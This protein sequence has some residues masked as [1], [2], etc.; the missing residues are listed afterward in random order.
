MTVEFLVCSK[1]HVTTNAQNVFQLVPNFQRF[2]A[3]CK[4]VER[5]QKCLG[6]VSLHFE[7]ELNAVGTLSVPTDKNIKVRGQHY[8]GLYLVKLSVWVCVLM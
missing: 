7:F 5:H 8:F 1:S 3:G 4:C 2:W 6:E